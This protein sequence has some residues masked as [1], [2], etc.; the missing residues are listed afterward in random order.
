MPCSMLV[1][2]RASSKIYRVF[3]MLISVGATTYN[4]F[5]RSTESGQKAMRVHT[6]RLPSL[7]YPSMLSISAT[8]YGTSASFR[9]LPELP[10]FGDHI[11]NISGGQACPY[12]YTAPTIEWC[13]IYAEEQAQLEFMVTA[14]PS[15]DMLPMCTR[16]SR[17]DIYGSRVEEYAGSYLPSQLCPEYEGIH[18]CVCIREDYAYSPPPPRPPGTY[19]PPPPVSVACEGPSCTFDLD[20]VPCEVD[21][22]DSPSSFCQTLEV[23]KRDC[24]RVS[25]SA[26]HAFSPP[27][28]LVIAKATCSRQERV[29]GS[30]IATASACIDMQ[31]ASMSNAFTVYDTV[32]GL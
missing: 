10:T 12:G 6:S 26:H 7:D 28:F 22:S 17:L 9:S 32:D 21:T 3:L 15:A 29:N 16:R 1:F 20:I 8:E 18:Y 27:W 5:V 24:L 14:A 11:L 13:Q 31:G 30:D 25:G 23:Q 4:P 2:E 19:N